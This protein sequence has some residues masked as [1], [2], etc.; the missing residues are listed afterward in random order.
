MSKSKTACTLLVWQGRYT[1]PDDGA[2][3]V[4]GTTRGQ[5]VAEVRRR[6]QELK[7]LHSDD[8]NGEPIGFSRFWIPAD[9]A[10]L[11]KW[12]NLYCDRDNG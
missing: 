5:V 3:L 8:E 12:L 11:V 10:G 9:R 4:W 2:I 7:Y 6:V 1:D